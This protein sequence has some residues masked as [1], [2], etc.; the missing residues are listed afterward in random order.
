MSN[1]GLSDKM[2]DKT[3]AIQVI[4]QPRKS[5]GPRTVYVFL[6]E[7]CKKDQ[8][9]IRSADLKNKTTVLCQS[10][11]HK[12]KPFESIYN[13]LFKKWPRKHV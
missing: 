6:C 8:C 5:G 2:I 10:C 3:K 12:K 1:R 4:K 9:R 11:S 7:Q 13:R